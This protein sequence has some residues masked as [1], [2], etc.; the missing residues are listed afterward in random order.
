MLSLLLSDQSSGLSNV[1]GFSGP[2]DLGSN[3]T[4]QLVKVCTVL[5]CTALSN[6]SF[7]SGWLFLKTIKA[8]PFAARLRLTF[9]R[10][11]LLLLCKRFIS[12]VRGS[13]NSGTRPY[14]LSDRLTV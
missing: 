11:D 9:V 13:H 6:P 3:C 5:K 10:A 7:A 8:E 12:P 14:T 4:C 1:I 2:P